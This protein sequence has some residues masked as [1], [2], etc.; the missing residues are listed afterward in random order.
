MTDLTKYIPENVD[1]QVTEQESSNI[2]S[3]NNHEKHM[4]DL[5]RL[6]RDRVAREEG[7]RRPPMRPA[8]VTAG[9]DLA[10]GRIEVGR[11]GG[12]KCAEERVVEAL[13]GLTATIRLT[14]AVRPRPETPYR[15]VPVCK[16]CQEKYPR[17]IF[18]DGTKFQ[19]S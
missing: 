8:T 5:A 17:S 10:T 15:E 3:D 1:H 4:F 19:G 12:G 6:E 14:E 13:G 7:P 2:N 18:P 11:S 16:L 9:F